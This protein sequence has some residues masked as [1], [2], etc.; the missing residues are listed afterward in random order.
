[1]TASRDMVVDDDA[2]LLTTAILRS[3]RLG[4]VGAN[5]A[6]RLRRDLRVVENSA[7]YEQKSRPLKVGLY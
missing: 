2:D 6:K 3:G 4:G 7:V 5:V 1:M